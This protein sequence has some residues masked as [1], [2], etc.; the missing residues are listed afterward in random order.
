ML[1]DR[2][3]GDLG[4]ARRQL[5]FELLDQKLEFSSGCVAGQQKFPPI[6]RRQMKVDI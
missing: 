6:G 2:N 5:K 4:E 3:G 1:V